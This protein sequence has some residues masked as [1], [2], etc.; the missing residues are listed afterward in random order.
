MS[1]RKSSFDLGSYLGWGIAA[2]GAYWVYSNWSTINS[3][4]NGALTSVS[5]MFAP[6]AP[7]TPT[8]SGIMAV[9]ASAQAVSNLISQAQVA[10]QEAADAVAAG[11]PN[12]S[13]LQ[14]Q[15]SQLAAAAAVAQT[16]A[17]T[18]PAGMQGLNRRY[19][20]RRIA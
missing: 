20:R 11:N 1:R 14:A 5:N 10:Q 16:T 18:V 6:A 12:A 17:P 19:Y 3:T 4:L 8:T 15:A 9:P 7:M 2:V 13:V